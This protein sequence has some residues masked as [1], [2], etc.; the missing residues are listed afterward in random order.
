MFWHTL[1]VIFMSLCKS[2]TNIWSK[3]SLS[4]HTDTGDFLMK[5]R[6]EILTAFKVASNNW[7]FGFQYIYL[8]IYS[9]LHSVDVRDS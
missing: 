3:T 1:T 5:M 6:K 4:L 2:N 9:I 8:T 7:V